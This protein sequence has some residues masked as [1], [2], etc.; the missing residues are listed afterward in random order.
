MV[1]HG[2]G[3]EATISVSPPR[4][5]SFG[6]IALD[7]HGGHL[8]QLVRTEGRGQ[9][10]LANLRIPLEGLGARVFPYPAF[11]PAFEKLADR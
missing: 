6:V 3:G 8:R 5:L 11:Q 4:P 10:V 1:Q 7:V 2:P 9:M